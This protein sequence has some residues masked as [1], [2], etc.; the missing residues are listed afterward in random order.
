MIEVK[1]VWR[2]GSR[3]S[4]VLRDLHAIYDG[5]VCGGE[6]KAEKASIRVDEWGGDTTR[7][8][9]RGHEGT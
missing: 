6:A 5:T 2:T 9:A 7:R 1:S 4:V 8:L 3:F